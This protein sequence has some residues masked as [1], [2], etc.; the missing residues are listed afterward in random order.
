MH[1]PRSNKEARHK[2]SVSERHT[3]G[4]GRDT[5]PG[6]IDVDGAR[7]TVKGAGGERRIELRP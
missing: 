7:A 6:V 1:V 3:N 2:A 5:R 4:G